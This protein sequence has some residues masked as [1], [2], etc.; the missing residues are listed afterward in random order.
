MNNL[1]NFIKFNNDDIET[2]EGT[3]R[4]STLTKDLSIK[5][6]PVTAAK[7]DKTPTHR[8][9]AK[10]PAGFDIQ[11]GAIWKNMSKQDKEY[12]TLN[13][14]AIEYRA[15]LGRYP[16]QDDESLQAIIEWD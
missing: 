8:I 6:V 13:I 14:K 12:F 4:I 9:Y 7:S 15:N 2:S 11:V 10:S 5:A 1:T 16:E 3:G